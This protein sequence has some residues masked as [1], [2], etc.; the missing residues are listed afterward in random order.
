MRGNVLGDVGKLV[1]GLARK[2]PV[3]APEDVV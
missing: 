1:Q 3:G 2:C